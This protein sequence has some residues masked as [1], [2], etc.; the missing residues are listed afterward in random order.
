MSFEEFLN[1][2]NNAGKLLRAADVGLKRP[3]C[4]FNLLERACRQ[5]KSGRLSDER[6]VQNVLQNS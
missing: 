1:I 2:V 3:N 5:R 6:A 4:P